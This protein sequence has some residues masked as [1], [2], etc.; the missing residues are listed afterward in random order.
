MCRFDVRGATA[1]GNY[2]HINEFSDL[3]AVSPIQ[4]PEP[5]TCPVCGKPVPYEYSHPEGHCTRPLC[6]SCYQQAINRSDK[7]RCIVCGEQLPK[8]LYFAQHD[9][10]RE[11]GFAMHQGRCK[12]YF[13]ILAARA[14]G[15]ASVAH[16]FGEEPVYRGVIQP[17]V[18]QIGYD[19]S[20]SLQNLFGST[21][22]ELVKV[23]RH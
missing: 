9:N 6:E 16:L 7:S 15:E 5:G 1:A 3:R 22:T 2:Q 14:L 20:P 17:E 11:I 12:D 13:S 23:R 4:I 18:Q 21:D 10:P 8:E 19:Q